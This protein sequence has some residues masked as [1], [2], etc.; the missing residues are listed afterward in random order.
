MKQYLNFERLARQ[1]RFVTEIDIDNFY[2]HKICDVQLQREII[3]LTTHASFNN[4]F[5][6][7]WKLY[8]KISEVGDD[9]DD[10]AEDFEN[11]N[12][13][14]F[15]IHSARYNLESAIKE[16]M[17]YILKL[18]S[19]FLILMQN[20]IHESNTKEVAKIYSWF[21]EKCNYCSFHLIDIEVDPSKYK[22]VDKIIESRK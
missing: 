18:K 6:E 5:S 16:F 17:S 22:L 4:I 10:I 3:L 14:R 7:A 2:D 12:C 11:F 9:L 20:K 15:L 13:N 1:G 8:D 21:I 19:D